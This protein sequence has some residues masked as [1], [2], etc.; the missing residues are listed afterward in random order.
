MTARWSIRPL[1]PEEI[2]CV[3]T[4][5]GLARLDQGGGHY[6]V[7]WDDGGEPLGHAYLALGDPPELQDVS[8]RERY[9]R[10]GIASA[11]TAAAEREASRH[12]F[13]RIRLTVGIAN[14]AAQALYRGL[15]YGETDVPP[16]RVQGTVVIRTGPLEVDDTLL[17]WEKRLG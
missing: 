9:R 11:L 1:A 17:T 13:D 4:V 14:E 2:E 6:L 10:R 12:G 7:A 16:K 8:V 15:G 5:L 3:A